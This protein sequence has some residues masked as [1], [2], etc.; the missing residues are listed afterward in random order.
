MPRQSLR[1][2]TIMTVV[3]AI[4]TAASLAQAQ[5]YKCK[6]ESGKTTYA[7]TPCDAVSKP[8]HLIDPAKASAT[9]PNMCAQLQDE[10]N[11]IAVE[12]DG[13][14]KAGR[15]PNTASAKR[16]TSLTAQY[17]ARCVGV[18]RSQQRP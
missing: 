15:P 7:D 9:D 1:C 17:E 5:V 12:A 2:A 13:N 16:K 6:D 18:S 8:L 4:C 11:R 10:L 14:T 3:V